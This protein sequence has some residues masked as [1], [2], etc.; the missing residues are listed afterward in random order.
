QVDSKFRGMFNFLLGLSYLNDEGI[1][2]TRFVGD[3]TL[4]LG[5][6]GLTPDTAF[7]ADNKALTKSYAAFGE[8]YFQFTDTLK[9]TLGARYT[10][11][12][13]SAHVKFTNGFAF[14]L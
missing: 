4:G 5:G 10:Y 3:P 14:D 7:G 2:N 1:F 11:E 8:G 12:K 6:T 9:A 13:R